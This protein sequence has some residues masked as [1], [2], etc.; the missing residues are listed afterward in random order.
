MSRTLVILKNMEM[1]VQCEMRG[2]LKDRDIEAAKEYL[3]VLGNLK[4]YAEQ[5]VVEVA[6]PKRFYYYCAYCDIEHPE[7]LKV[8]P[9][10]GRCADK[11]K[12][13]DMS[14]GHRPRRKMQ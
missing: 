14:M 4:K 10:C 6:L 7:M 9:Y 1:M 8:K 2:I 5:I 12:V 13:W 3:A 11:L